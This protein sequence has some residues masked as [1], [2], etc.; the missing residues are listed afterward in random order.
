MI[1]THPLTERLRFRN[2]RWLWHSSTFRAERQAK[3]C[4]YMKRLI[5]IISC[6]IRK[7]FH[8]IYPDYRAY[9]Y[10]NFSDWQLNTML[11]SASTSYLLHCVAFN[12]FILPHHPHHRHNITVTAQHNSFVYPHCQCWYVYAF[13]QH[14][15]H[16]TKCNMEKEKVFQ[17]L[18]CSILL[19]PPI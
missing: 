3:W 6:W 13:D 18:I 8:S 11:K 16:K 9:E 17:A 2:S 14:K 4:C 1:C 5:S 19:L 12:V 15:Q 10:E 7:T